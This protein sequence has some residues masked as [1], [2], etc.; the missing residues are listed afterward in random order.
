MSSSKLLAVLVASAAALTA[1]ANTNTSAPAAAT[2]TDRPHPSHVVAPTELPRWAENMVV[3][4]EMTVDASG[5][6]HDISTVGYVPSDVSIRVR[7]AVAQW[8]FTP[9]IV[10]GKAVSTRVELPLQLVM[11]EGDEVPSVTKPA[12]LASR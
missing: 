1:S 12:T 11:G 8:R 6:P 4:L 10:D 3:P 9:R 7:K 5:V 2:R